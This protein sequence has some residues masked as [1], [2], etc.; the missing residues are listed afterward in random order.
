MLFVTKATNL[1]AVFLFLLTFAPESTSASPF[2]LFKRASSS[3]CDSE[4]IYRIQFNV[5]KVI[6]QISD[7]AGCERGRCSW[8]RD[9]WLTSLR[10]ACSVSSRIE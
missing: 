6:G 1:L 9:F 7:F 5:K 10:T 3:G 4:C 2:E 8:S